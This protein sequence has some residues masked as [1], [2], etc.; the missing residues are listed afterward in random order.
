MKEMAN[1]HAAK[2]LRLKPDF[3]VRD[4]ERTEPYEDSAAT[5]HLEDGLRKAG[6]S[7]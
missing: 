3:S 1:S 6:L 5:Q 2:V 7:E 4:I